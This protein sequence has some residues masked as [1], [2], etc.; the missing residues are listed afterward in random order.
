MV[1]PTIVDIPC[2]FVLVR[3]QPEGAHKQQERRKYLMMS[4]NFVKCILRDVKRTP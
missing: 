3:F 1:D 4:Q 2:P